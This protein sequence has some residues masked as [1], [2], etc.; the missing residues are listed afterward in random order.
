MKGLPEAM[1]SVGKQDRL[2]QPLLYPWPVNLAIDGREE[3]WRGR[4]KAL[5]RAGV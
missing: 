2:A 1:Q 5:V 4:G 3:A